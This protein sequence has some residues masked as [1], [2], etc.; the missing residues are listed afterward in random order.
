MKPPNILAAVAGCFKS[1]AD[2][3]APLAK[4]LS[5]RKYFLLSRAEGS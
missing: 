3:L 1:G 4:V 2:G 5:H